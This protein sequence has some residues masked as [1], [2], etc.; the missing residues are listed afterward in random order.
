MLNKVCAKCGYVLKE[1]E[2]YV[3]LENETIIDEQCFFELALELLKAKNK[4][5]N[6]GDE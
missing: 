2:Y 1:Y 4:Q 5:N 3:E 6:I